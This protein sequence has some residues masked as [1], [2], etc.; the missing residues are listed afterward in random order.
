[1]TNITNGED[2]IDEKQLVRSDWIAAF[3]YC[4]G[5][6]RPNGSSLSSRT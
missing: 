2:V 5:R 4:S 6:W 3:P 1:V